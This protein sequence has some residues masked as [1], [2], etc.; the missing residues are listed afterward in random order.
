MRLTKISLF[1]MTDTAYYKD[2]LIL[3]C[4]DVILGSIAFLLF[5]FLWR[6]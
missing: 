2:M 4:I 1:L 6:D 3:I 5:P